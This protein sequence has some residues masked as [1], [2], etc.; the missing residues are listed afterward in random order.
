MFR[1]QAAIATE[2]PRVLYLVIELLKKLELEFVVCTT[3][4]TRCGDAKVVIT[5]AEDLLNRNYDSMV[6]VEEELDPD[7]TSVV[8]LAKLNDVHEPKLA[9]VGVDPGM[10]FGVALVVDG[11]VIF[12]DSKTSLGAAVRMTLS[13]KSYVKRLFPS[14]QVVIRVGT[15][16]KL[17][18][19]L[20]LRDALNQSPNLEIELVNEH[21]TTLSGGVT[22]DQSSAILIAG[23]AGRQQTESDMLLEPKTGY[24]QSL[25]QYVRRVTRGR[26]NLSADEARAI[27]LDKI[28]LNSILEDYS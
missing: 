21:H 14:C 19:T 24:V 22:S 2:N 27:L 11:I 17:Y 10:R 5:T 28:S 16:A 26:R 12:K 9:V 4:D 7:F 13:L 18:A 8:I 1:W 3:D 20:F 23:R 15:G 25:R 6:I